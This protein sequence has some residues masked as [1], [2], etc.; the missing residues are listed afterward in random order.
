MLRPGY[1]GAVGYSCKADW[2]A[3][4]GELLF[5]AGYAAV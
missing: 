2:I 5:T 1:G 3:R 4:D